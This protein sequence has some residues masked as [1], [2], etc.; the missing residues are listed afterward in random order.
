MSAETTESAKGA[1]HREAD[2][3]GRNGRKTQGYEGRDGSADG[4]TQM[5]H[6]RTLRGAQA[7]TRM[8][9]GNCD[10]DTERKDADI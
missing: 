10:T 5:A 6:A 8:G 4:G 2:A 1:E 3:D 9:I 7:G